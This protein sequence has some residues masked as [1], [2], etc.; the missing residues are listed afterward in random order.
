MAQH[1]AFPYKQ[2]KRLINM[3]NNDKHTLMVAL[4]FLY[5]LSLLSVLSVTVRSL[6]GMVRTHNGRQMV[7]VCEAKDVHL[8]P[9]EFLVVWAC[10]YSMSCANSKYDLLR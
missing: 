7:G 5:P 8:H 2:A 1:A 3:T 9:T 6:V 10:V 4:T